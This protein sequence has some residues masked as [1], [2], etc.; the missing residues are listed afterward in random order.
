MGK[1]RHNDSGGGYGTMCL[2]LLFLAVLSEVLLGLL[3]AGL[4]IK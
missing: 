3:L 2:L 4:S 1:M